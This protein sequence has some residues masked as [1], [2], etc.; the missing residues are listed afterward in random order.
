MPRGLLFNGPPGTGK[1][2][3]AKWVAH[4]LGVPL[5]RVDVAGAKGRFVGD[6][7]TT[8][9]LNLS[10]V[11]QE[12]PCVALI[13]EVEKLFGHDSHDSGTTAGMLSQMLWWLAEHKSRVLTIMTTNNDKILPK[14]LYRE[15]RIDEV[16][17]FLGVQKGVERG[18]F[19]RQVLLTFNPAKGWSK[20]QMQMAVSS[21]LKMAGDAD[22]VPQAKLTE[23]AYRYLKVQ[24]G[25]SS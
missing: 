23:L 14:E 24:N 22:H 17:T 6:S 19:V 3:G 15:G 1:T 7:E 5:F 11:D 10:R 21:V 9:A 8:L 13:D 20:A 4:Q 2:S 12:E 25:L 16:M 18:K